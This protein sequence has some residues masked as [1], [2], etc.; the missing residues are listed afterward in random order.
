[1]L[2]Q[3]HIKARTGMAH[4]FMEFAVVWE[5]LGGKVGRGD[6]HLVEQM[7]KIMIVSIQC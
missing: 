5:E 3:A 2:H 6:K 7:A 1:M 4:D